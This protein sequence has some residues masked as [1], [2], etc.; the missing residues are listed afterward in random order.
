[1]NPKAL[2][3][4]LWRILPDADL[5]LIE[6]PQ[7]PGI[8]LWLVDDAIMDRPLSEQEINALWETPAYWS[9]AWASGQVLAK[10]ILGNPHWVKGKRVLDFGCG[11][12]LVAI[13]AAMAGAEEVIA[14]D[15]DSDAR[16]ATIANAAQNGVAISLLDDFFQLSS[17]VD[18]LFAADVLYDWENKPLLP[19]FLSKA[20]TVV[21]ADSRVREFDEP[22]Y[23]F[24]G[25]FEAVTL[26]DM[27]ELEEFKQVKVFW[28]GNSI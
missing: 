25:I 23:E 28:G 13:A 26:P 15:I 18:I 2:L 24:K 8:K 5:A 22:G 27:R 1:M 12:G 21:V 20:K 16:D 11:S 7:T 17:P 14:C 10:K 3:E 4:N 19:E 9:F 6:M